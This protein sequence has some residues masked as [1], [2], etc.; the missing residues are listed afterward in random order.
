MS[1]SSTTD[2]TNGSGP[3]RLA[4]DG[5][6]AARTRT[7][8]GHYCASMMAALAAR[9]DVEVLPFT[10][11]VRATGPLPGGL[12]ERSAHWAA[13]GKLLLMAWHHLRWPGIDGMVRGAEAVFSPNYLLLP[14]KKPLIVAIHDLYFM[15]G[16]GQD[17]FGGSFLAAHLRRHLE[18]RAALAVT[19]SNAVRA[20]VL[21]RFPRM[22]GRVEVV[23]PGL[24]QRYRQ[25]AAEPVCSTVRNALGVPKQY[26]LCV[27]DLS[28]RKNQLRVLDARRRIGQDEA[29][30]LVFCGMK[31]ES[32]RKVAA[33]CN[34]LGLRADLVITLPYLDDDQL[35]PL[36]SG[37]HALLCPSL[38]EGFGLV[39]VEALSLGIPVA[40]A[41]VGSLPEVTGGLAHLF[42][43]LDVDALGA[44]MV[45][46]TTE[47]ELRSKA[48]ANGPAWTQRFSYDA[49]ACRLTELARTVA[50]ARRS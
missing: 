21:D 26:L 29:P 41:N 38:D 12:S 45:A 46:L 22:E 23:Y 6:S 43:P 39:V 44:A 9:K 10:Y 8:I 50:R 16:S 37:A 7:G 17:Y 35:H 5:T 28:T 40:C 34:E 27:G 13:P 4:I 2:N 15:E 36:M 20:Q 47:E 32:R 18:A 3:F 14:T 49:A 24:R 19:D 30:P 25:R 31:D 48:L 33:H 42:D 1:N 11:G